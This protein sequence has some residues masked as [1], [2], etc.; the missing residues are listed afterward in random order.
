[1][2]ER[3]LLCVLNREIPDRV[4]VS[5]FVQEEYLSWYYPDREK[6]TRL[7]DAVDCSVHYGFDITTRELEFTKPFWLKRSYPNW[8]G[9]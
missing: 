9:G 3:R 7:A 1:M 4:P 8:E 5:F 6:V 2:E